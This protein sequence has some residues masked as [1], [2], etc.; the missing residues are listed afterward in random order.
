MVI[1]KTDFK[2]ITAVTKLQLQINIHSDIKVIYIKVQTVSNG[3][4]IRF[5]YNKSKKLVETLMFLKP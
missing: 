4:R 2:S 1:K 3:D 5:K